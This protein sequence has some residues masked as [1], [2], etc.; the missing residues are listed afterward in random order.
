MSITVEDRPHTLL[1]LLWVR[2]AYE[3]RPQSE[4][5]PPLLLDTPVTV[6]DSAVSAET[7][8]EWEAAWPG[9][10][11]AAVA[12]VGQDSDP[13]LFEELQNTA[14]GSTERANHLHRIVGRN[15]RDNFGDSAFDDSYSI[16]S[17]RGMDAHLAAMP[18]QLENQPERR[19]L[20]A[21]IPAWRAGLTKI[22][23]IPCSGEFIRRVGENSLLTTAATRENSDSY[24]R[25]LS[26][27]I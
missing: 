18:T 22:V 15:W 26:T 24:R 5:L 14:D 1:E 2:E 11:Q 4:N 23:T 13:G 16:W 27:F 7:R 8:D 17:Q 3:L 9:I 10:W 21:L 12:H 20:P 19:D 6:Q 25:A